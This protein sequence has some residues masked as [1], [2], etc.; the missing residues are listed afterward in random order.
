MTWDNSK[1]IKLLI[2]RETRQDV[3]LIA[4]RTTANY[5][6]WSEQ[7]EVW[8]PKPVLVEN[9]RTWFMDP[10]RKGEMFCEAGRI[11]RICRSPSKR[12]HPAGLTNKFK[13]SRNARL[14]DLAEIAHLV[15][16]DWHW[17]T[18]PSGERISRERWAE[19]HAANTS[20][21][22]GGLVSV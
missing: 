19:I 9:G 2:S 3:Y 5:Y 17:M 18:G 15:Q 1:Y 22:R 11:H 4:L 12:G 6:G 21:R 13:V 10:G 8:S 20:K 14:L 7:F 16:V